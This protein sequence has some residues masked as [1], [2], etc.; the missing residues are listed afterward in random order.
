MNKKPILSFLLILTLSIS[1]VSAGLCRGNDGYYHDCDDSRYFEDYDDEYYYNGRYYPS[2][3]YYYRDYYRPRYRRSSSKIEQYYNDVEEYTRTTEY[4]Y[5]DRYGYENIKTSISEKTEIES[6][7]EIPYYVSGRIRD[8]RLYD[9]GY[10]EEDEQII[11]R[12]IPWHY[13]E[14]N[15]YY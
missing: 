9:T 6:N 15:R 12:S 14:Y 2:R 1:F 4:K 10:Y 3:A 7:Y 5:K 11:I 8:N 13:S